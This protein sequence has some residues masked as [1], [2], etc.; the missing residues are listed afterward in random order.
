MAIR[1]QSSLVRRYN[2]NLA[3]F[4]PLDR[5]GLVDRGDVRLTPSRITDAFAR[6]ETAA[7]RIHDAGVIPVTMGGDGSVSLPL[8]RAAARAVLRQRSNGVR[9]V[10]WSCERSCLRG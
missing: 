3:D 5:L 6:I 2:P 10:V 4:D 8:L 9:L 7:K 1:A